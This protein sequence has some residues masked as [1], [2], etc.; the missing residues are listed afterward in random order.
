MILKLKVKV[1]GKLRKR[2]LMR[3]ISLK[4]WI[5]SKNLIKNGHKQ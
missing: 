5:F 2:K 1:K 3:M 4:L